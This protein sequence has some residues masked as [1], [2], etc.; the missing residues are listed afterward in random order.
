M[1]LATIQT[2]TGPRAAVQ[3]GERFVDLQAADSSLPNS[4]K[5]LVAL[6]TRALQNTWAQ[7]SKST[8]KSYGTPVKLLPPIPDPE[9]IIC[10]GLN[11]RDHAAESGV[12]I[13]KDPVLFS[14]YAT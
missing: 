4:V 7:A 6:G 12:P 2:E 14:K 13:P 5:G 9:K 11:Y 1:R 8:V 3:V 10:L